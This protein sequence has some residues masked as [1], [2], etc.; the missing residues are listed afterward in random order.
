MV[1]LRDY[2]RVLRK[3]WPAIL[4]CVAIGAGV[5]GVITIATK[6]VYKATVQV[7]VAT[8]GTNDATQLAQGNTFTQERVQSY[9]SIATSPAVTDPVIKKLRLAI[10]NQDLAAKISADAPQNKVLINLHVTDRNPRDAAAIANAVAAQFD[11]VVSGTEQTDASGKPVVK[12]SVIHPATVPDSAV[13]PNKPLNVGLGVVLGLLVGIGVVVLRDLLD[14][15][16]KG[17]ADLEELDLAVLG[18]VPFDKRASKFPIAFRDD[19]HGSRAEA[20]RQLR[21]NLLFVNVDKPPRVIAVTSALPGEGKTTTA[22][23]L[24]A[25][26]AESG[27]RVCLLEADLRRPSLARQ[28]G[29][30]GE[31]GFTTALIGQAPVTSLMQN[32]GR[33]LAVLTSG[34]VPPNP[35]ELLIS[36]HARETVA[37]LAEQ[38]DFVIID[39]APLLPVTDGAEVA[40]IA[41]ATIIVARAGKTTHE[42]AQRSVEALTKVDKAAAGVVLNRVNRSRGHYA[43][44]YGYYYRP[45]RPETSSRSATRGRWRH[46]DAARDVPT[47][48]PRVSPVPESQPIATPE[49]AQ[50]NGNEHAV[51][52]PDPAFDDSAQRAPASS[53]VTAGTPP[54]DAAVGAWMER[55]AELTGVPRNTGPGK[56]RE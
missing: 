50:H 6:P 5:G 24:A 17:P 7:F 2:L 31:V 47:S 40:T 13:K 51:R 39:T 35:S 46:T 30:I 19:P 38:V 28:L 42:Q 11:T 32:V 10:D 54:V 25:A 16:L 33:N 49:P 45:Y 44:E 23:N 8:S 12:L 21:T 3:G 37:E 48:E 15:T 9:T 53:A 56:H 43:Y 52:V 4:A 55:M 14:S 20:Y 22:L 27:A 1:E 18:H 29:L 26:L 34:P 36:T 41:D